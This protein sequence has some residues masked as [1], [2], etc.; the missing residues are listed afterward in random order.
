MPGPTGVNIAAPVPAQSPGPA[1]IGVFTENTFNGVI[2]GWDVK[3]FIDLDD[4]ATSEGMFQAQD[5]YQSGWLAADPGP[6]QHRIDSHLL[7][8]SAIAF[9]KMSKDGT[10]Y[11]CAFTQVFKKKPTG[12]NDDE[13]ARM[14][15][16][17]FTITHTI[18]WQNGQWEY[19]S[20]KTGAQVLTVTAGAG[21]VRYPAAGWARVPI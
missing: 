2:V 21:A 20:Q 4:D 1:T 14:Q 16:S 19:F 13:S 11:T 8:T 9:N 18:T 7:S 12:A 3:E 15:N 6:G 5:N 17:G 10:R